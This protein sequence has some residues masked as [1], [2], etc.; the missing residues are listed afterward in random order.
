MDI[1]SD[2]PEHGFQFPGVFEITAMGPAGAGLEAEIPRLLVAA[3]IT[4]LHETVTTRGSSSG[5][6]V[7]IK[8]S[9]KAESRAQYDAAHIALREHPEVKWT[10]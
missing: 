8:L 6:Y 4:V 5:R 7:S 10:L 9:F 2:N 3:G 1:S